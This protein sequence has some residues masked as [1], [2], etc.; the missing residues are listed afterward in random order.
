MKTTLHIVLSVTVVCLYGFVFVGC[1]G[2]SD[3]T[4]NPTNQFALDE[5][6]GEGAY[7]PVVQHPDHG[8]HGGHMVQLSN[9]KES[10]VHFDKE[11]ELFSVYIDGL[12]D[13]SKVQMTTTIGGNETVY[14]FARSDTP[15]GSIYGLKSPELATAVMSEE[16]VQT[17]LTITTAEGDLTAE[18]EHQSD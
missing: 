13:V 6:D 12:G 3:T 1:K 17:K 5:S 11:A 8:P 14:D 16:A 4:P 15:T 2:D 7:K 10:E 18:F 9:D